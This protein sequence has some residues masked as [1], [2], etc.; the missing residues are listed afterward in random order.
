MSNVLAW[1]MIENVNYYVSN[2]LTN[3]ISHDIMPDKYNTTI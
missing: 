3:I 2:N 1:I